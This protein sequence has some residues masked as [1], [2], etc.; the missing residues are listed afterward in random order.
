MLSGAA[1]RGFASIAAGL[2]AGTTNL[3]AAGMIFG[4][5]LTHGLQSIA[6]GL[7]GERA[8]SGGAP[9]A[10]LGVCLHYAI[11]II[12]AAIYGEA[13]AGNKLLRE[14]WLVGGTVF[15]VIAYA[16]MNLVV[17][18]LSH[19]A[20]PDFSLA[21]VVKELLAHAI[22]FGIPIAGIVVG[23]SRSQHK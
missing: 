2:V 7:I 22:M 23:L 14:R 3:I 8:F 13:A 20:N 1:R 11:S 12:A 9:T 5:T 15:G 4:G 16:V 19:A 21:V 6:S 17:V 10:V 18:P